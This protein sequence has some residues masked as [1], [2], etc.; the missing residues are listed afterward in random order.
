MFEPIHPPLPAW[1]RPAVLLTLVALLS[2]AAVALALVSQHS[3]GMRPCPWCTLQRFIYLLV[4]LLAAL[5]AAAGAWR[6]PLAL[7]AALTALSGAA[8]AVWQ[9]FHAAQDSSC[10]F[11]FADK[12][13]GTLRLWDLAPSVFEPTASCAQ[14]AVDLLGVPYALWSLALFLLLASGCATACARAQ[15]A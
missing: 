13:L 14:S 11:T 7:L 8:A 3:Y 9:H 5:G 1:Q 4:A 12:V 2:L 15:R 10:D 6:R